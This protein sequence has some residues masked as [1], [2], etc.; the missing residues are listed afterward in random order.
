M[1]EFEMAPIRMTIGGEEE[2]GDPGTD[3]ENGGEAGTLFVICA[4]HGF[5]R[6]IRAR[7]HSDTPKHNYLYAFSL[8]PDVINRCA[9]CI[10]SKPCQSVVIY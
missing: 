9:Q 1:E 7:I 10:G 5:G 3:E 8:R 2:G 4:A 6:S